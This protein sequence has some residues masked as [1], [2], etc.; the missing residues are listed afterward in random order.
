MV[1][2]SVRPA[3]AGGQGQS[4]EGLCGEPPGGGLHVQ[5]LGQQ[6]S[7]GLPPGRPQ[8][9]EDPQGHVHIVAHACPV[10]GQV[11]GKLHQEEER[12]GPSPGSKGNNSNNARP[13]KLDK[14][15]VKLEAEYLA[16]ELKARIRAAKMMSQGVTDSQVV[17]GPADPSPPPSSTNS[18]RTI[19]RPDCIFSG[20]GDTSP[21]PTTRRPD[22]SHSGRGDSHTQG[23]HRAAEDPAVDLKKRYQN[24]ATATREAR[25]A[26]KR[27]SP[28]NDMELGRNPFQRQGA[29][30]S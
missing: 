10:R 4:G 13:A 8:E 22:C 12:P 2:V 23:Y 24:L 30:S 14:Y 15:L 18:R 9:G 5:Q 28:S 20:W 29:G 3:V 21:R 16:E 27:N 17:E 26:K 19:R 11:S 6:A 7:Q 1:P 25:R